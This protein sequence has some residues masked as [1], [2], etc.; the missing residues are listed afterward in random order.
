MHLDADI[1]EQV[2]QIELHLML[3]R[4]PTSYHIQC[5]YLGNGNVGPETDAWLTAIACCLALPIASLMWCMLSFTVALGAFCFQNTDSFGEHVLLAAILGALC[6]C[7]CG[8]FLYFWNTARSIQ[9]KDR[10]RETDIDAANA[11]KWVKAMAVKRM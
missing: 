3:H 5:K 10:G 4:Q 2:S 8:T 6:M 1:E 9:N 7:A 11:L